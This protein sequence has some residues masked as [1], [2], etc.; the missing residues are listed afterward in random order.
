MT[1]NQIIEKNLDGSTHRVRFTPTSAVMTSQAMED[2][3]KLYHI[4]INERQYEPLIAIPLAIF[5]FLCIH[6]FPDG[7]GRTARLLTLQLLYH[8]DYPRKSS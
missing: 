1:D 5:D 2:L 3:I 6:P 7:N 4:A 8:F